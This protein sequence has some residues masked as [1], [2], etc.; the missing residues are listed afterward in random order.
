[1]KKF[2]VFGCMFMFAFMASAQNRGSGRGPGDMEKR[3]EELKKNLNLNDQQVDSLKVID[4]EFFTKMR[5]Q[6]EKKGNDRE[7]GREEMRKMGEQRDERVKT[8][9][10]EE[11]FTKYKELEN[12]RRQRGPGGR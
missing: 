9:L 6:R 7:K 10:T 4:Q 5:E 1:M 12:Q 3:Y 8:I 2:L 11:Q